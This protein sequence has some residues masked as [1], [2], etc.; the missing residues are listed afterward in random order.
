MFWKGR[1]RGIVLSALKSIKDGSPIL[2]GVSL[3]K[4]QARSHQPAWAEKNVRGRPSAV[5]ATKG[6]TEGRQ[7]APA[8]PRPRP[9]ETKNVTCHKNADR[10]QDQPK[11]PKKAEIRKRIL[12]GSRPE[13]WPIERL[14]VY[15]YIYIYTYC[16]YYY[17][18]YY[19]IIISIS[20]LLE[21]VP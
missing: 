1:G 14:Q 3:A 21:G 18:Y 11:L 13:L 9:T 20:E 2:A 6:R 15:T 8:P 7:A 5:G 12:F 10:K 17:Y 16:Y 4:Q 19:C